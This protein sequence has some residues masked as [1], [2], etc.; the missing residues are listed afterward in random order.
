M[1]TKHKRW[2]INMETN[3]HYI[4]PEAE[5]L[6]FCSAESLAESEFDDEFNIED[7]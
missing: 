5:L 1:L 2:D 6:F 4:S 7:L 3:D